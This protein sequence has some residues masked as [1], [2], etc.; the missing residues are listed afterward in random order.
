MIFEIPEKWYPYSRRTDAKIDTF[1]PIGGEPSDREWHAGKNVFKVST[2]V[3][4]GRRSTAAVRFGR[5]TA[6]PCQ[7]AS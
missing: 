2:F 1:F 7:V 6:R 5:H 4:L 3:I